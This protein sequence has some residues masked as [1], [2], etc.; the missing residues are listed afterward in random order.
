MNDNYE[1]MITHIKSG[2]SDGP[3]AT[4]EIAKAFYYTHDK[5]W[6]EAHYIEGVRE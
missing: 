5:E 2:E 3:F 4:Y 6:R 1:Y